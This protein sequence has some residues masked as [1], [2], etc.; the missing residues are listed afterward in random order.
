MNAARSAKLGFAVFPA[1]KAKLVAETGDLAHAG[2]EADGIFR[3]YAIQVSEVK[4]DITIEGIGSAEVKIKSSTSALD[5]VNDVF[6]RVSYLGNE[7]TLKQDGTLL[8]DNLFNRTPWEIGLKRFRE[9]L[10]G[11]PLVLAVT[12]PAP[13]VEIVNNLQVNSGVTNLTVPKAALLVGN[14]EVTSVPPVGA[15]DKGYVASVTVLP[16]YAVWVHAAGQ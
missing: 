3:R 1:P 4:P 7:A 6:L 8:C 12:S 9:K 10:S 5:G 2:G 16:E 13:I 11:A 14:Y 15:V